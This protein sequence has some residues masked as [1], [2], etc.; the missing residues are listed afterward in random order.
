MAIRVAIGAPRRRLVRQLLT[1]SVVLST[2]G[3]L[4]GLAFAVWSSRVLAGFIIVGDG[5]LPTKI[6]IRMLA[7]SAALS[8]VTGILFGLAPALRT[9]RVHLSPILK[10]GERNIVGSRQRLGKALIVVQV[11]LSLLLVTGAGLFIRTVHNLKTT[12]LG[13]KPTSIERVE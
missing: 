3:G 2:L 11:A 1:E 12:E 10:E 6:D 4:S 5:G 9:T 13:F 7:F 8:L